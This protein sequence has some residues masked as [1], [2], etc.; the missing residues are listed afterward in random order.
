MLMTWKC[1]L[2]GLPW[3]IAKGAVLCNPKT[4][5]NSELENLTRKYTTATMNIIRQTKIL[6]PRFRNIRPNYGM[7]NGYLFNGNW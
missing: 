6:L 4:M 2:I 7:G 3:E 5:S 1:S